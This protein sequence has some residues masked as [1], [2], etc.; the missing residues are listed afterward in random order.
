MASGLPKSFRLDDEVVEH[1]DWLAKATHLTATDVVQQAVEQAYREKRRELLGVTLSE[2]EDGSI[3]FS[4]HGE[5]VMTVPPKTAARMR[6]GGLLDSY[7]SGEHGAADLLI[8]TLFLTLSEKEEPV[9]NWDLL[10]QA[11][12]IDQDPEEAKPQGAAEQ[13]VK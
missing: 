11:G 3:V 7:R 6:R 5:A 10:R 8:D 1:I 12:R 2:R 9:V 4:F 13:T